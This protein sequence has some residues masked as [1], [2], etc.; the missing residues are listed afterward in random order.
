MC[1][2][3]SHVR[4]A[5]VTRVY[6]GF[7]SLLPP[8]NTCGFVFS[9]NAAAVSLCLLLASCG[10]GGGDDDVSMPQS[11]DPPVV[12]G[13]LDQRPNN[14]SC[15]APDRPNATTTLATARAFAN[16]SFSSPVALKQAPGDSSRWFVVEQ[17]GV[18]RTFA[19]Q[20]NVASASV[21]IDLTSKVESGGEE[22]LLGLAFH[23][24]FPTNPRVYLSYTARAGGIVSRISEFQTQ[25]GG[26]TLNPSTERVLLTVNQPE[27]NHNGGNI[28]FGPDGFL[29]I[30]FGDGGGGGDAHGSIGNGQNL[31]TLLGKMLRIDVSP[32]AGYAIPSS[33]PYA[34]N[35]QCGTNG[36]GTANCPEIFAYGFRNPWRWSF[37]R[38]AKDLWVADVGQDKWEEVDRVTLGGNFGWRCREGAHAFNGACGPAQS[39][40]EPIAEYSHSLGNS[41]T[42]GYVY[43]GSAIPALQGRYVFAD[44]G[45]GRI[46]NIARDTTP[47]AQMTDAQ[48]YQSG[49]TISS[50]GEGNDG[51][52][53]VVDYSGGLYKI[54]PGASTGTDTIPAQL[55]ATGCMTSANL[56][57]YKPN[58][59]FWSDGADKERFIGLPN[60]QNIVVGAD[61]D[62]DFPNGAVLVKN[63]RV[64]SKLIETRLF[65]RHP[66][67]VWAGYTYEWNDAQTDA[68]RVVGGKQKQVGNQTWIFPSESECLQCHTD[69]AGRS[70]GLET[71]QLNGN[72]TYSQTG[73]TANQVVTLNAIRSLSPPVTQSPEQLPALPDPYGTAGSLNDRARAYLHTNC[74]QCHRPNGGT[75]VALDLRYTTALNQTGACNVAPSAGDLGIANAQI[76]AA[77]DAA[78]S[79][80]LERMKRRD[81]TGVQMPPIASALPDT[82]GAALLQNWISALTSCN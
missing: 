61:G 18:V 16:L 40:I 63:F 50:F 60:G 48:S 28:S 13:G 25:D 47:T 53:Y 55:S 78:R 44:F 65:M 10:G 17:G 32:A 66:D 46:W 12:T 42:G 24:N 22:G 76:I 23:P 62:W 43:R 75:P 67:G 3:A 81:G 68:T 57:G 8:L 51:E 37:D 21:F 45:S 1:Q 41:I 70:L 52:L 34:S 35:A 33:N 30:G 5:E 26:A 54:Q 7:K 79:V 59:P 71:A 9:T 38:Q 2:D 80:L 74:A 19:N 77:G 64:S 4:V 31:L 58:A 39:L 36:S 69:A 15:V 56:I 82:Q 11:T 72:Y 29:Y 14:A 27:S 73:R 49:L 6:R 20:S